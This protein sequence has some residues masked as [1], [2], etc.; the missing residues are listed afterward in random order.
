MQ[1]VI[2]R[3]AVGDSRALESTSIHPMLA[4]VYASRG[5]ADPAHLEL[6]L[7]HL[8][9]PATLTRSQEAAELL[10]RA[11]QTQQRL[12]IVGDVD[13]D[14]ATSTAVAVGALKSMGA[15]H[16]DYLVPNRF[17][18][19][20][21][22]TPEIVALACERNPDVIITVDNGISSIEG[23][24]AATAAG[25]VTLVTDH[26]LAGR[27]LPDAAVI[28]NPN[29]PDCE[30]ASKALAGVGVI[31]YVMLALRALLRERNW[32]AQQSIAEPNLATYLDLVA[33]GTVADVVPLDRNNRI[34]VQGGL[35]RIRS[36]HARPGIQALLEVAGRQPQRIVASDLGFLYIFCELLR[37]YPLYANLWQPALERT[38]C[39]QKHG[40]IPSLF[41][42]DI[43]QDYVLDQTRQLAR[44]HR[45]ALALK[46]LVPLVHEARESGLRDS[47]TARREDGK[48]KEFR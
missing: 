48:E 10:A 17:E 45:D 37:I 21:G 25:I 19:G 32:F 47:A 36:G 22:L 41:V 23:L 16:V 7:E 44:F 34:L 14:G 30:F 31:F 43:M 12:L 13:A 8:L 26:H 29:Q 20:Y 27:Q 15:A 9:A 39:T 2:R 28:V 5:V 6:G 46:G 4:R 24:A 42:L 18:Y 11:L 40:P 33:L 3:R 1:R 35:Q 38:W